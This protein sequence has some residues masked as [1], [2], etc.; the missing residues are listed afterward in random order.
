MLLAVVG[1]D[2]H[3]ADHVAGRWIEDGVGK[4][5]PV[6]EVVG[7]R[8]QVA[9]VVHQAPVV[10]PGARL[11]AGRRVDVLYRRRPRLIVGVVV[12]RPKRFEPEL[13]R[14]ESERD[15]E[16][17]PDKRPFHHTHIF[18]DPAAKYQKNQNWDGME[19]RPRRLVVEPYTSDMSVFDRIKRWRA[20]RRQAILD[21]YA[22]LSADER[23]EVDELRDEHSAGRGMSFGVPTMADREM[24]WPDR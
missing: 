22:T 24:M 11:P 10:G 14:R 16:T 1:I 21:E 13:L 19:R 9:Q 23:A 2:V 6:L 8:L 3:A 18:V 5:R 7:V 15:D 20:R 4:A 17:G 12:L